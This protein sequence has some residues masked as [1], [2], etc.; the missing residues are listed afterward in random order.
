MA[1][2]FEKKFPD[3]DDYYDELDLFV[4]DK[5]LDKFGFEN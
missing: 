4:Y 5:L 2:E 3:T 1:M